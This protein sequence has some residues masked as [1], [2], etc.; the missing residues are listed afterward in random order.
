MV[1]LIESKDGAIIADAPCFCAPHPFAARA[2]NTRCAILITGAT[3]TGKGHLARWIH[4]H[5]ARAG[6][7]LVPVNCGAI[8]D[9]L[10]DSHLFGHAKG[11]FSGAGADHLGLVRAA[12]GGTL[13][14]DEI[15]EL[16]AS[17]QMRLLRLLEDREVQ[18]IGYS[19][20]LTVNVRII[21]ATNVDLWQT[22]EDGR[23]RKDLYFRLDVV[24]LHMQPLRERLAEIEPLV[25]QFNTEFAASYRHPEL[26]FT[27]DAFEVFMHYAWPGNIRELRTVIERL[28][29]LCAADVCAIGPE[30][31]H[32][33][34]QL[35]RVS[36][37]N[38]R[39]AAAARI[40]DLRLDVVNQTLQACRGN[41]SR[42]AHTLGV[43]R[44]TLYRWLS[45]HQA[46]AA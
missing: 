17:A 37:G 27:H 18:P 15:S 43:H 22:V 8:P 21:A 6:G 42:A 46:T 26:Q 7:P 34:G 20:P 31:L 3:G 10:I 19:R 2:A 12:E 4:D 25:Q 5:S 13:L 45:E 39:G 44:S 38:P 23:F 36:S 35:P 41:V 24:K 1:K 32:R 16:P 33:F 9:G 14:L 30:E 11:S 29:V 28:H 40:V